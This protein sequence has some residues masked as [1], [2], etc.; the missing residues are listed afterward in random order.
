M[1]YYTGMLPKGIKEAPGNKYTGPQLRYIGAA[2]FS[3]LN[4]RSTEVIAEELGAD[5]V[6]GRRK[7]RRSPSKRRRSRSKKMSKKK[8]CNR[9]KRSA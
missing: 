9:K 1:Y 3:D 8:C 7:K 2:L 6:D 5:K 4:G